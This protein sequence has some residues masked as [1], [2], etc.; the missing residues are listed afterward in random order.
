MILWKCTCLPPD[1]PLSA[2]FT[3]A[4]GQIHM[5]ALA[6]NAFLQNWVNMKCYVNPPWNLVGRVLS[7]A[8]TQQVQLVL[9]ASVWQAQPWFPTL[10]CM[11]IDHSQLI[12]PTLEAVIS[13]DPMPLLPQ[14]AIW[15]ISG[16]DFETR[17]RYST[18][19]QVMESQN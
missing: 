19:A 15:Y 3:S 17:R 9:V 6:T 14:L 8:Q 18:H 12:I 10:P 5:Y 4:G 16:R 7:Q 2:N 11:L 1:C 13:E